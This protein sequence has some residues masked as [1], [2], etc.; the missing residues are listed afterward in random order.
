MYAEKSFN[1]S[2]QVSVVKQSGP[3][4][5]LLPTVQPIFGHLGNTSRIIN[6]S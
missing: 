5:R 3:V 6:M 2:P 4:W 1:I